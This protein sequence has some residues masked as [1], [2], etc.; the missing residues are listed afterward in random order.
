MT[1]QILTPAQLEARKQRRKDRWGRIAAG[2]AGIGTIGAAVPAGFLGSSMAY[3]F[4]KNPSRFRHPV[5]AALGLGSVAAPLILGAS[6]TE[7]LRKAFRK[8]EQPQAKYFMQNRLAEFRA[9]MSEYY[10]AEFNTDPNRRRRR[11][12]LGAGGLAAAG[13]LGYGASVPLRAAMGRGYN[14]TD[15]MANTYGSNRT[16]PFRQRVSNIG[17]RIRAN[18]GQ[19]VRSDLNRVKAVPGRIGAG[20]KGVG[21]RIGNI[22]KSGRVGQVG[23]VGAG[24]LAAG[25]IGA[26]LRRRRQPQY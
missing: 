7:S 19:V 9:N 26:A 3:D 1:K 20:I 6:G 8:R 25:G 23:L 24:L 18:A 16:A 15:T 5:N 14:V 12:L 13:V 17:N 4:V 22:W 2:A 11:A 10:M 21:G